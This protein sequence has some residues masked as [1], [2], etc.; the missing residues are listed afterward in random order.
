MYKACTYCNK[1]K[2][3]DEFHILKTGFLGRNSVCKDCRKEK[4]KTIE[5]N[6]Q[7]DYYI[8]NICKKQ[9]DLT[10][11]YKKKNSKLGIQSYCKICQKKQIAKSKSKI[12]NFAKLLL[13]KVKRKNKDTMFLITEDDIIRKFNQQKE[14]CKITNHQLQHNIDIKQRSDNVWNMSI[15]FNSQKKK[16][17][18]NDFS[19]VI[20][21][22][23]SIKNMY[24][25]NNKEIL[26]LYFVIA[27]N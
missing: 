14:K 20:N 5:A 2:S 27:N 23:Y 25:L 10:Q 13:K 16:I 26:D 8:C 21:L 4:R 1:S 17:N 18:Y 9:K 15:D 22:I 19:L 12:E 24:N 11:F 3:L 7:L 6:Y